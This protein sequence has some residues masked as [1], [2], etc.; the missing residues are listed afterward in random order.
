MT[1]FPC[2]WHFWFFLFFFGNRHFCFISWVIDFFPVTSRCVP[3]LTLFAS[4]PALTSTIYT[5]YWGQFFFFFCPF[6]IDE[7]T[8]TAL[9]LFCFVLFLFYFIFFI[10][11]CWK[12]FPSLEFVKYPTIYDNWLE[13]CLE[14]WYGGS[15]YSLSCCFR[16]FYQE[17]G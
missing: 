9:T 8:F 2:S 10:F 1:S 6:H 13:I 15:I 14:G 17:K 5:V 16:T 11:L 7:E 3:G 12:I 4:T